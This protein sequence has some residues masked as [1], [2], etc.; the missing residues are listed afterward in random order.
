MPWGEVVV[1]LV[2]SRKTDGKWCGMRL[3]VSEGLGGRAKGVPQMREWNVVVE[4]VDSGRDCY[5][6]HREGR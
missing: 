4:M 5:C 6:V 2:G 3:C 1:E